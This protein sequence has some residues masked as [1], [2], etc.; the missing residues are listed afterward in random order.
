MKPYLPSE[1]SQIPIDTDFCKTDYILEWLNLSYSIIQNDSALTI[2]DSVS[3]FAQSGQLLAIMGPSGSG[4]TSLLT[5]LNRGITQSPNASITGSVLLNNVP[6]NSFRSSTYIKLVA[7]QDVLFATQTPR[8]AFTFACTLKSP[9]LNKQQINERV[10]H[11]IKVL[12]LEKI[13]D[14][15]IGNALIQ[16]LSGGEKKRVSIGNELIAEP[17]VLILDEPTSGLDS[18]NAQHLVEVLV[19]QAKMGKTIIMTIHQP[20]SKMFSMFDRLIVMCKGQIVFQGP[21]NKAISY[22]EEAGF[23]CPDWINPPEYFM[24]VLHIENTASLSENENEVLSTLTECYKMLDLP[25]KSNLAVISEKNT[26]NKNSFVRELRILLLRAFKNVLRQK[27]LSTFKCFQAVLVAG[28]IVLI[29]HGNSNDLKSINNIASILFYNTMNAFYLQAIGTLLVFSLERPSFI[30]EYSQDLYGVVSFTLSKLITEFLFI[31]AWV[32]LYSS[33]V[34]FAVPYTTHSASN[35]FVYFSI[36]LLLHTSGLTLGYSFAALSS[37]FALTY[38]IGLSLGM[39]LGMFGGFFS[40]INS[41]PVAF[42][43]LKYFSPF[44]YSYRALILNQF[45][46]FELGKGVENPIDRLSAQGQIW[47][48]AVALII[49]IFVSL[50][51]AMIILKIAGNYKK[52]H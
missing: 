23:S 2:L 6:L 52:T 17:A 19:Q 25:C 29:C 39:I 46:D 34:Y 48:C 36:I 16:G 11:T 21:T 27:L 45:T 43:W 12:R 51:M 42:S 22:F 28:L 18:F 13:C 20:S 50:T 30:R 49:I 3:G 40:N 4:K 7:Q 38:G 33:I 35:F 10:E 15:L 41:F 32:T 14:N 44:F 26:S 47:E 37:N 24:R 31:I 8:E 5:L 1:A 9:F